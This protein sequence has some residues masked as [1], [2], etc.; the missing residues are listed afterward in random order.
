MQSEGLYM[1]NV[2]SRQLT[3]MHVNAMGR[4]LWNCA[5]LTVWHAVGTYIY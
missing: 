1:K 4:F 2:K 3:A 5:C